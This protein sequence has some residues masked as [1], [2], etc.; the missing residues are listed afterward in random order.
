MNEYF[1]LRLVHTMTATTTF[2]FAI[3]VTVWTPPPVA[4]KP[5]LST[6]RTGSRTHSTVTLNDG[7]NGSIFIAAAV[8]TILQLLKDLL[9][10]YF[11]CHFKC[12]FIYHLKCK[13][14]DNCYFKCDMKLDWQPRGWM[15]VAFRCWK[16]FIVTLAF[17][18]ASI[19]NFI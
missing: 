1:H 16:L 19:S 15:V 7:K 13:L 17:F 6:L 5:I 3:A 14:N 9:E 12:C 8:W 2:L 11:K 10:C 4:T 18:N